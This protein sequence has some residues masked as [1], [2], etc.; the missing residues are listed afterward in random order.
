MDLDARSRLHKA[1]KFL[2]ENPRESVAMVS[3]IFDLPVTTLYSFISRGNKSIESKTRL[4]NV[5]LNKMLQQHQTIAVH[6]FIRSLL[7]YSM[8]PTKPLI[9]NSIRNLKLKENPHFVGPSKR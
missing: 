2:E 3:R 5:E 4:S 6:K 7:S 8:P 9:F 1:R